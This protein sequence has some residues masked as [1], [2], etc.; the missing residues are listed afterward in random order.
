MYLKNLSNGY[1][2][3]YA[4]GFDSCLACDSTQ[5]QFRIYPRSKDKLVRN[6]F[7]WD[8]WS[9]IPSVRKQKNPEFDPNFGNINPSSIPF[10]PKPDLLHQESKRPHFFA[11]LA[12][13]SNIS[14][15]SKN[16]MS[17][18]IN[19][20]LPSIHILLGGNKDDD[21]NRMRMLVDTRL[22]MNTQ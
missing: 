15:S 3:Q 17:V 14:S 1:D 2:S 16:F 19:N 4:D 6:I 10:S 12:Y 11:I 18:S 8:L 22:A 7:C 20:S 21:D 13:V 5:H 9:H